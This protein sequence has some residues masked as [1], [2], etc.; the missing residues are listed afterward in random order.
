MTST[1]IARDL[2]LVR[3]ALGDERLSYVGFS[4][5]T[6]LG[7][8]YAE[9]YPGRVGRMVLDGA[10]D[11]NISYSRGD[12]PVD[13]RGRSGAGQ[14]LRPLRRHARLRPP[15]VRGRERVPLRGLAGRGG[16]AV[17]PRRPNPQPRSALLGHLRRPGRRAPGLPGVRR[18][19]AG[20]GP[21]RPDPAHRPRRGV[22]R[23][24]AGRPVL[25]HPLR[26]QRR[27]LQPGRRS[28]WRPT[29]CSTR[30]RTSTWAS[31]SC[32]A[33]RASRPRRRPARSWR[34]GA[35]E[36]A[37]VLVIGNT[38][39]PA[40]PYEGA[41]GLAAV[42]GGSRLLTFEGEGHTIAF[43][44]LACVDDVVAAYLVSG[45]TASARGGVPAAEW[46]RPRP[47]RRSSGLS[48]AAHR[49]PQLRDTVD[50]PVRG[51]AGEAVPDP[52]GGVVVGR[53]GQELVPE[54]GEAAG[55]R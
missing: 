33:A 53:R 28:S 51:Q 48:R 41:V 26:R 45:G 25:R 44:G 20:G 6:L 8:L 27:A 16:D 3:A 43:Q 52:L 11:P 15:A 39:D 4:W 24:A 5:G 49:L 50:H 22:R 9:L 10:I 19:V 36:L 32:S 38:L 31:S 42:L 34:S 30:R 29:R 21:G 55:G 2:D 17:Q 7:A 47:G 12:P 14:L 35:D 23:G 37:P 40:T 18:V 1:D 46:H 13:D 54:A